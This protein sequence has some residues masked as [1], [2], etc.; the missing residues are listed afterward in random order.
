MRFATDSVLIFTAN[1]QRVGKN[2][3]ISKCLK[4]TF[5]SFAGHF[6]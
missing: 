1:I 4:V 6:V 3:V 5:N 2:G